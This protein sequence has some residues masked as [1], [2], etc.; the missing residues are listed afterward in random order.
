MVDT[1]LSPE[2]RLK[3]E[4]GLIHDGA[5]EPLPQ[6]L[7]G[8]VIFQSEPQSSAKELQKPK[9]S[10]RAE[11]RR[12]SNKRLKMNKLKQSNCHSPSLL[13]ST[14]EKDLQAAKKKYATAVDERSKLLSHHDK[15]KKTANYGT[16]SS[17]VPSEGIKSRAQ[18]EKKAAR[19]VDQRR[20]ILFKLEHPEVAATIDVP[21]YLTNAIRRSI[22]RKWQGKNRKLL[23]P[24][25]SPDER[26]TA[27]KR[28]ENEAP[29]SCNPPKSGSQ[30][31]IP[32][33]TGHITAAADRLS[34]TSENPIAID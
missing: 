22:T 12:Q 14:P 18:A 25:G 6:G 34:G 29:D 32:Q 19:L 33:D 10:E 11:K 5:L 17:Q 24:V 1:Y 23:P 16:G 8:Y 15:I 2:T 9:K 26:T 21:K 27:F 31:A 7:N 4:L 30:E 3:G 28:D 20:S 13:P